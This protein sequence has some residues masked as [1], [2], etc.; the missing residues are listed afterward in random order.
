MLSTDAPSAAVLLV[1]ALMKWS[2]KLSGW[3]RRP[4]VAVLAGIASFTAVS[5]PTMLSGQ[6]GLPDPLHAPDPRTMMGLVA[7][8]SIAYGILAAAVAGHLT[9]VRAML[10]EGGR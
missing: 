1:L 8:L 2:G 6:V 5:L 3:G 4:F 10:R 7:L 9:D